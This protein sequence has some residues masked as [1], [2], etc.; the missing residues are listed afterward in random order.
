[1]YGFICHATINGVI[2]NMGKLVRLYDTASIRPVGMNTSFSDNLIQAAGAS[3]GQGLHVEIVATHAGRLTRNHGFYLPQKMADGVAS[4]MENFGK[5]MLVHHNTH[6]DPVGRVVDAAYIDTSGSFSGTHRQDSLI[7]DMVSSNVPFW[8][9]LDLIDALVDSDLIQ[10]PTYPGLGHIRATVLITDQSAIRKVADRRLMTVSI[11]A[12]TDKA[13][14]SICKTDW[15]E[16]GMCEHRPGQMYDEKLCFIIAGKLLYDEISFVNVPADPMAMVISIQNGLDVQDSIQVDL[17]DEVGESPNFFFSDAAVGGVD[18][19]KIKKAWDVVSE[20]VQN[21]STKKEDAQKALKDFLEE[22]KDEK[23]NPYR[24]EAEKLLQDPAKPASDQLADSVNA[25]AADN[26]DN[27]AAQAQDDTNDDTANSDDTSSELDEEAWKVSDQHY[28]NMMAFG[29]ELSLIDEADTK[30]TP[31]KRRSLAKA[32]FSKPTERKYP[33]KDNSHARSALAYAK[34]TDE[35]ASVIAS[36]NRK[37]DALGCSCDEID[38]ILKDWTERKA[39]TQDNTDTASTDIANVQDDN[40]STDT[41]CEACSSKDEQLKALRQELSDIYNEYEDMEKAYIG[42]VDTLQKQS[43][44]MAVTL[45][46]LGGKA[47]DDVDAEVSTVASLKLQDLTKR[48]DAAQ[49]DLDLDATLAKLN[50]G[51]SSAAEGTVDDPTVQDGVTNSDSNDDDGA[52]DDKYKHIRE[53]YK[54]I[55]EDPKRGLMAADAYIGKLKQG[56][57]VPVDFNPEI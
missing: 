8:R 28:D 17:A 14:C 40:A 22:F 50:D 46:R 39:N 9:S 33:V 16:E 26:T 36:I 49:S 37:A 21:D 7:K 42:R 1:M 55:K 44:S 20:L 6:E 11:G 10:D 5:P 18:M 29:M 13:V 24:E 19:D 45:E 25:D 43:A 27:D 38:A 12:S 30:L 41:S 57:L 56:R 34:H 3:Q 4:L 2:Q 47:I 35:A 52:V 54:N 31:E 32:T 15:V 51:M 53:A 23:D 48:I